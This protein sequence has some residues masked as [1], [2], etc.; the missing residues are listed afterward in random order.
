[1]KVGEIIKSLRELWD[2]PI[3]LPSALNQ[4]ADIVEIVCMVLKGKLDMSDFITF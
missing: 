1:M 3:I 2:V 4:G